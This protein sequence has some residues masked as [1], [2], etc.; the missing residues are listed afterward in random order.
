MVPIRFAIDVVVPAVGIVVV[1]VAAVVESKIEV[2]SVGVI[3]VM[4]VVVAE[5]ASV[6]D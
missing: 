6:S 2:V 1:N 3:F 5:A 4:V